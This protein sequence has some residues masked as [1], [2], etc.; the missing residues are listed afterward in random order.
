MDSAAEVLDRV[1]RD[2][3][4]ACEKLGVP[5]ARV[6]L[7]LA[8]HV[9]E[10][11]QVTPGDMAHRE[12]AKEERKPAPDMD[13]VR[14]LHQIANAWGARARAVRRIDADIGNQSIAW[15]LGEAERERA[16]MVRLVDELTEAKAAE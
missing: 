14:A 2:V 11:M 12:A 9:I 13:R 4:M 15:Y 16:E 1:A 3:A 8:P 7:V 10:Q 5:R 6:P